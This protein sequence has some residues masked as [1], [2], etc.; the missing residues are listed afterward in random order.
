MSEKYPNVWTLASLLRSTQEVSTEIGGK[1]MP[2]R[3][4]GFQSF[5][6]RCRAALLVFTGRADAVI[7]PGGQ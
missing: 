3:P 6:E 5:I 2:C 7:W 4:L 1:Y